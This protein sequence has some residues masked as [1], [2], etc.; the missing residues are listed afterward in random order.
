VDWDRIGPA[1]DVRP[2]FARDRVNLL[3]LLA[4]LSVAD[5]RTPT[6]CPGWDVHDIVAHL[7][8]DHLRRLSAGRDGW[9]AGWIP[10]PDRELAPLLH[11]ANDAF[12]DSARGLSPRVL[13]GLIATLGPE[14]DAYWTGCD[15]N[16]EGV[17]V[18]WAV[19]DQPAPVWLDIAREYT[20]LW[21][22]QQQIRD[23]VASQGSDERDLLHPVIDTLLRSLPQA[24]AGA[25]ATSCTITVTAPVDDAWTA[26]RDREGWRLERRDAHR[27]DARIT[28]APDTLWRVAT[29]G[30]EP[31][32]ALAKA[33]VAGDTGLA[34]AALG[35]TSI[36]R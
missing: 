28:L 7:V 22:H 35:L 32:A 15:L 5:W 10:V 27:P 36:I 19:P 31:D 17:S 2:L 29:R 18:S 1:L 21:V 13:S 30:L 20:E 12:V 6:V 9:S 11:R 25:D 26:R 14:L 24:L 23:A 33:V 4:G 8:H 3:E 34:T 16:A